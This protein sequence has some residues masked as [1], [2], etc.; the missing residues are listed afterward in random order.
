M[1]S[2]SR[3]IVS[4]LISCFNL[5][6]SREILRYSYNSFFYTGSI[7]ATGVVYAT[8]KLNGTIAWRLPLGM[9]VGPPLFVFIGSFL[10]PEV[11][12]HLHLLFSFHVLTE[13]SRSESEM[14]LR[15]WK[16]GRGRRDPGKIPRR[17]RQ[18]P[19]CCA[20]RDQRIHRADYRRKGEL[21]LHIKLPHTLLIDKITTLL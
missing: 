13:P 14:A 10:I 2:S 16:N 5:Y 12:L 11:S 19:P 8:A 15:P 17:W 6:C 18:E 4:N 3:W 9:Q 7:L 1:A 20:A 21:K